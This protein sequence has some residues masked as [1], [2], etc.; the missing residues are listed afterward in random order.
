MSYAKAK[1]YRAALRKDF[2]PA[3][4]AWRQEVREA[5]ANVLIRDGLAK[6]SA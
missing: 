2:D 6:A 3:Y 5:I 4:L 1:T